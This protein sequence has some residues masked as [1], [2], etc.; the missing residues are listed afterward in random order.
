MRGLKEGVFVPNRVGIMG[1][2]A[3]SVGIAMAGTA[4]VLESEGRYGGKEKDGEVAV[5]KK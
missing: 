4:L 2:A 1:L 5:Q 3:V